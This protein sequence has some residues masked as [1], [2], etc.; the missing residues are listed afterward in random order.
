MT[1]SSAG[2]R[3]IFPL[4]HIGCDATATG[5]DR[6]DVTGVATG[7]GRYD[8]MRAREGDASPTECA[9]N[10]MDN[11]GYMTTYAVCAGH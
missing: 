6:R 3:A 5:N 9:V 1:K 8:S 4:S 7:S 11:S 2:Y 10:F